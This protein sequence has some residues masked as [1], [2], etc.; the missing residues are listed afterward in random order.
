M[1]YVAAV[2]TLAAAAP[3]W[4]GY[5]R[6]RVTING[7]PAAD[8]SLVTCKDSRAA[9]PYPNSLTAGG[10]YYCQP[11]AVAGPVSIVV[12][13][14]SMGICPIP[15]PASGEVVCNVTSTGGP[16]WCGS[17]GEVTALLA[18]A[19]P[20]LAGVIRRGRRRGR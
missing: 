4:A 1:A 2:L 6:G 8:G 7:N 5:V 14:M 13:G 16:G 17:V 9:G 10:D 15:V 18:P 3:S 19:A 12:N 20:M 11:E